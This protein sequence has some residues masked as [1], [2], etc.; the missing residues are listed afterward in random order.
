[1]VCKMNN[2][3]IDIYNVDDKWSC[4]L[5]RKSNNCFDL[6]SMMILKNIHLYK[7]CFYSMKDNQTAIR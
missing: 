1:M 3:D 7:F 2:L 4:P 6:N 5:K